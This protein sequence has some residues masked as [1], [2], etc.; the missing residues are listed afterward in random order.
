MFL[1]EGR[2]TFG[3]IVDSRSVPAGATERPYIYAPSLS[4]DHSLVGWCNKGKRRNWLTVGS[5]RNKTHTIGWWL[6]VYAWAALVEQRK[7]L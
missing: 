1:L 3:I 2:E 6:V 5:V 7:G 4:Y